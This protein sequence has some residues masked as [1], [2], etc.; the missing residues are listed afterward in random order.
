MWWIVVPIILGLVLRLSAVEVVRWLALRRYSL[1]SSE[2]A[3]HCALIVYRVSLR[4]RFEHHIITIYREIL[5]NLKW[6]N[7]ASFCPLHQIQHQ[8]DRIFTNSLFFDEIL[9]CKGVH[10]HICTLIYQCMLFWLL[11]LIKLLIWI[12]LTLQRQLGLDSLSFLF[13]CWLRIYV[14]FHEEVDNL[15]RNFLKGL[16]CKF[17]GIVLELSKWYKLHD[18]SCHIFAVFLWV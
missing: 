14:S 18:I 1:W 16:L 15:S 10:T 13:L 17:E 2:L 12:H 3:W 11:I 6:V 7:I 5:W 9:D 8:I 4:S